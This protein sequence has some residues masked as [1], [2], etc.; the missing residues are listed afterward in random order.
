MNVHVCDHSRSRRYG[1]ALRWCTSCG[2]I[3]S[4]DNDWTLPGPSGQPSA[5]DTTISGRRINLLD[6]RPGDYTLEDIAHHLSMQVRFNGGIPKFYGVGEHTTNV[7]LAV[8]WR[9]GGAVDAATGNILTSGMRLPE[10]SLVGED[11]D[12]REFWGTILR[13]GVHDAPEMVLGDCIAPLKDLLPDYQALERLHERALYASLGFRPDEDWSRA[14]GLVHQADMDVRAVEMH[15]LRNGPEAYHP[16]VR[17]SCWDWD[18][19]KG[20]LLDLLQLA[21]RKFLETA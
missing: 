20:I 13:A 14:D 10:G 18:V 4:R 7:I 3:K 9:T 19:A 1:D 8:Y 2:A 12:P 11:V 21:H 16:Q 5:F 15:V 17:I 6:P